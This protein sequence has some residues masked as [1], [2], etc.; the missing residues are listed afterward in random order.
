MARHFGAPVKGVALTFPARTERGEFVISQRGI[1]G[2]GIY[3]LSR[4][5]REG[6]P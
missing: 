2:G 5:L 6:H 4:A 1:E 3:P